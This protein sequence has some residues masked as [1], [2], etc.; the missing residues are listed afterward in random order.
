MIYVIDDDEIMAECITRACGG[1]EVRVFTNAIEA[2]AGIANGEMPDLIFLDVLLHG[3][4]GFTMLNE[5][6]SYEDTVRVPVVIVTSL[7]MTGQDLSA[8]GV[9]GVLSKERMRPEDVRRYVCEYVRV[10][11][12]AA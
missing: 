6:V 1:K 4:D 10:D 3:P 12:G 8:Y 11:D 7:D 5:M 9:V 2:M